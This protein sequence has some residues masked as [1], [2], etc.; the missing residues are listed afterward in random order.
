MKVK[1]VMTADVGFC[2]AEET[3]A[4]AAAIMRQRDCGAVPV[5]DGEKKVIGMITD[6]DIALA[7]ASRDKKPSQIKAREAVESGVLA[8]CLETDDALDALKKMRRAKV[9][10]LAVVGE[11]GELTGIISITDLILKAPKLKKKVFS[12]LKAIAGPR[13]IVLKEIAEVE[14]QLPGN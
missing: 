3:L 7:A 11:N 10:R 5:V 4:K 6:R 13:P 14:Q 8:C 1:K 12:V 2:A 9:G